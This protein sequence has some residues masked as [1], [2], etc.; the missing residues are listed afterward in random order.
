MVFGGAATSFAMLLISR[1]ALGGLV[2][3]AR[4][5]AS[6]LVGDLYDQNMRSRALGW[7]DA[8]ALI[9]TGAG[10]LIAASFGSLLT[11][12]SAFWLLAAAGV[13]VGLGFRGQPEPA[14]TGDH[15][16]RI[17]LH[18]AFRRVLATRTIMIV[19]LSG[20]IGDF[21]FAGV[22]TFAVTF[23]VHRYD[24]R[25][26]VADLMLLA[27][28]AG[29]LLGVLLGGRIGDRVLE[30]RSHGAR[31]VVAAASFVVAAALFAPA[32]LMSSLAAAMPLYF[33]GS[34]ALALST[35]VLDAIRVD[36][37]PP[38]LRGRAE[39]VRTMVQIG[40]EAA[41]PLL[42]GVVADAIG[43]GHGR[44]LQFTFLIALGTLVA[45]GLAL[46][47][48]RRYYESETVAASSARGGARP[49]RRDQRA[50]RPARA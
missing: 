26:F 2:A 41:A 12:R 25:Q 31:V 4:P 34:A 38:N 11:W 16:E 47:P 17:P 21:F 22:R 1:V 37:M 44:G 39:S 14:R 28:G 45:S 29:G 48:A 40:L 36:V 9:G 18:T 19:I 46:L 50:P 30:S 24:V 42:F 43:G 8:G 13:V 32:L 6:S 35:P 33:A 7:I 10:V 3:V 23:T 15:E 27:V 49:A 5:A 20:A